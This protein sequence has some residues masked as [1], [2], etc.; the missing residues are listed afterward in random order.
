MKALV[1]I[2]NGLVEKGKLS[3]R[4]REKFDLWVNS[5][6]GE[7]DIIVKKRKRKRSMAENNYYWGVVLEVIREE[8]GLSP[9]EVHDFL[10]AK[11]LK[12]EVQVKG[13]MFEIIRSTTDLS[14]V[15][16]EEYLENVRRWAST[17]L[18]CYIP[19]PN[20]IDNSIN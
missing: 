10:K 19:L 20:E 1:P 8:M 12:R 6:E 9:E 13:K 17:E 14:T 7:V 15:E 11:F 5:L 3:I 16:M 4:N 18:G 2:F